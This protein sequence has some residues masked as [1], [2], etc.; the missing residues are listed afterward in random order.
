[1]ATS[2][3]VPTLDVLLPTAREPIGPDPAEVS[4]GAL[5]AHPGP[6]AGRTAWVRANMVTTVDGA[7][8]G[9]DHLSGSIND[10]AD[11]RVFEVLRAAADVVVIGAGTARAERYRSL[12][13]PDA[14]AAAR[15][16]RGQSTRLEL[17]VVSASGVLPPELLTGDDLPLVLTVSSSPALPALR[18]RLGADRVIEA[19]DTEVDA[20]RALAAL[21]ARGLVRVLAEGGP[22][23]LAQLVRSDAVDELCL[24]T[25]PLLVGGPAA[26]ILDTGTWLAPPRAATLAHLLHSDGVLLARWLLGARPGSDDGTR[27]TP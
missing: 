24:T 4:L 11:H 13:V 23:L 26:R 6:G 8:T 5:Y 22:H 2:R 17:A 14:L 18:E 27:L 25:S 16:A 21:A 7:A 9:P 19:G 1:M 15:A 12:K 10:A 3:P 20:E